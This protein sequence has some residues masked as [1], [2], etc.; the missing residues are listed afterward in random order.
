MKFTI[1]S[2]LILSSWTLLPAQ[3][4]AD[5]ELLDRA[6]EQ[7]KKQRLTERFSESKQN[8][9]ELQLLLS[10]LFLTY[11]TVISSQDQNR[12]SFTPSCSEYGLLAVKKMG[13]IKGGISTFDRLTRCNGLNIRNY[14]IDP[15]TFHL[16]DHPRW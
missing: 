9:N 13:V 8:R 4:A 1:L 2:C 14:E 6:F 3:R 12:C 15:Q 5:Y 10:G 7:K 11:K 16:I